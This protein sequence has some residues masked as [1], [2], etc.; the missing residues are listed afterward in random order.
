MSIGIASRASESLLAFI[1]YW[2]VTQRLYNSISNCLAE[3]NLMP[4][5]GAGCTTHDPLDPFRFAHP[6]SETTPEASTHSNDRLERTIVMN[7]PKNSPAATRERLIGAAEQLFSE[8]GLSGASLRDITTAASTN[9]AAVNYHFG[10][11]DGLLRAVLEQRLTPINERR[12]AQLDAIEANAQQDPAT[13]ESVLRAF[14]GPAL[15]PDLTPTPHFVQMMAR[16]HSSSDP[17]AHDFLQDV[18]GPMAQRFMVKLRELLPEVTPAAM[19]LRMQF[20]IGA[21]IHSLLSTQAAKCASFDIPVGR[22]S[23]ENL[24]DEIVAFCAAGLRHA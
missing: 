16:L 20:V 7:S 14:I 9:L 22:V 17:A 13:L 21:M 2:R 3:P 1:K 5:A 11:K 18:F 12:L 6:A 24:M 15:D 23:T 4:E 19:H 10:S 8:K